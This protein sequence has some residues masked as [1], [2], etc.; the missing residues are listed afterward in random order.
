MNNKFLN[1]LGLTKRAG[2]LVEGYNK[3]EEYIKRKKPFLFIISEEVSEKTKDKFKWYCEKSGVPIL[4]NFS[5]YD[6]GIALGR[7]EINVLCVID[8]KMA[9]KLLSLKDV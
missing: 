9:L 1:F 7:E 8:E 2:K 4:E 6:L 5:K 3:C